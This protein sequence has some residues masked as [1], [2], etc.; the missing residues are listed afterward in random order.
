VPTGTVTFR[1][2]DIPG[3]G[4]IGVAPVDANGQATIVLATLP[5]GVNTIQATYSGES[6]FAYSFSN[7]LPEFVITPDG[8][9]VA[10]VRWFSERGAASTVVLGFN[11][12]L[13]ELKADNVGNYRLTNIAGKKI[14][15]SSAVYNAQAETVTLKLRHPVSV[16]QFYTLTVTGT[17]PTGL[18]DLNGR[19][20]DGGYTSYAGSNFVTT[21]S[22][23]NLVIAKPAPRGPAKHTVVTHHATKAAKTHT[24]AALHRR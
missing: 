23:N 8:P 7:I 5:F 9:Q 4:I 1:D 15:I 19:L 16:N 14:A 22:K 24:A 21:L 17:T 12:P 3:G 10:S 18:T 20:L 2:S 11:E 6:R 13:Y